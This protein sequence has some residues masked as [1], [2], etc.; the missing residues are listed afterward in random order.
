MHIGMYST[1]KLARKY[2]HYYF[3][4]SNGKGHGI[5]SPFVFDF[6]INVLQDKKK[7]DCY[8]TIEKLR[9]E[10][11]QNN[12]LIDIEDHGAG[13]SVI[14]SNKR[15]VKDIAWSSLKNKNFAQLIYRIVKY[16]KPVTII[17]LGTSFGI[18]SSYMACG[19]PQ[20]TVYTLEGE[21]NIA[22]IAQSNFKKLGLKNI[23]LIKGDFN[24]GLPSLLQKI[25]NV[26][27]VFVDGHH[28]KTP[29]LQYFNWLLQKSSEQSVFIF[30]DIHWSAEMEEAWKQIQQ[31]P[32]AT[33]TIDLFF[34][35]IVFFNKDLKAKQHLVI[36]F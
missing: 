23:Q 32:T 21:E 8:Q 1:F 25:N 30:D 9:A 18:T 36:R 35:G 12:T 3:A 10:L 34:I 24:E 6:I 13:S 15:I 22:L 19:N 5:H 2:F 7:Y 11:L 31:H 14:L 33:L 28:L 29:T 4:A 17:E 16:Y 27:L 26:D 20:S